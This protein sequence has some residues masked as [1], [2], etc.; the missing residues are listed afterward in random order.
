MSE[1][2]QGYVE[3]GVEYD[4]Y[5][6]HF[7]YVV[8]ID[9]GII[10][11]GLM[12]TEIKNSRIR[13]IVW[14][15]LVNIQ[16]PCTWVECPV[17]Y[18]SRM[19]ADWIRHVA[20]EHENL[21]KLANVILIEKQPPQGLVAVEQLFYYIWREKAVFIYPISIHKRLGWGKADYEERKR[22]SI[23]T[24][25]KFIGRSSESIP[26][27]YLEKFERLERKHDITDAFAM[28]LCSL[29]KIPVESTE[30]EDPTVD[31]FF[32]KYWNV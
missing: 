12:L 2:L 15:E 18:H 9:I 10:N 3:D 28:V 32:F 11:L 31:D 23:K 20:Y 22:L 6:N 7:Q 17:K 19:V 5:P 1:S 30:M 14:F 13:R 27:K 26:N 29:D 16:R 8:S 24:F 4:Y 21:F 25:E